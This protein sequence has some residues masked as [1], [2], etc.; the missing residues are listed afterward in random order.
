MVTKR[1]DCGG[2]GFGAIVPADIS[3]SAGILK[4]DGLYSN[5]R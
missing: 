2:S 4:G 1:L 3:E 5:E